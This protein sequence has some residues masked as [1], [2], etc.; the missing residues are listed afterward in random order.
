STSMTNPLVGNPAPPS[1]IP[2]IFSSYSPKMSFSERLMN[3]LIFIYT[4]LCFH[5][6]LNPKQ[7][8]LIKKYIP[9][10]LDVNQV[11]YNASIVL[12]NSHPSINQPVPH[13]PS[14]IEIGGF[15]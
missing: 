11:I 9:G 12:L 13:V 7:N 15:H 10:G 14:M 5:W 8:E 6:Q 4:N 1:Y 2:D 3:S